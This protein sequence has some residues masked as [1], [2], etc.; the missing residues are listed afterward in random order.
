MKLAAGGWASACAPMSSMPLQYPRMLLVTATGQAFDTNIYIVTNCDD[1]NASCI[2]GSDN[3]LEGEPEQLFVNLTEGTQ[4]FLIVDGWSLTDSDNAGLFEVVLELAPEFDCNDGLD[5]DENGLTDCDDPACAEAQTCL[6]ETNCN[7]GQDNDADGQADCDD[8]DCA[9]LCIEAGN[10]DDGID[11]DQNGVA[12]CDD[13]ACAAL[14]ICLQEICNDDID[15][16]GD[17]QTDCNDDEC[18]GNA[19]C[20]N[21]G[22]NC[23]NAVVINADALPYSA[24]G[25][26]SNYKQNY[27]YRRKLLWKS[28]WG[29]GKDS[30]SPDMVC[31]P[32]E[33]DTTPSLST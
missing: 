18:Y 25:D 12:D 24:T 31:V 32:N 10:C 20:K 15:N 27:G 8:D 26:T 22:N 16:D 9:E 28:D 33:T 4:Y 1:I 13:D 6:P 19:P 30:D 17:G 11:N 3:A 21:V 5:N 7:D 2:A 23:N 14:P 29:G